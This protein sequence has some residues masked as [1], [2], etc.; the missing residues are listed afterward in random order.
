[1]LP[2]GI[3]AVFFPIRND[4]EVVDPSLRIRKRLIGAYLYRTVIW[5]FESDK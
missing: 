5:Y 2:D 4:F 1:M 3:P